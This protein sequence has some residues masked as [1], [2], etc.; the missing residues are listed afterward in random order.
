MFDNLKTQIRCY[1]KNCR[2]NTNH[3]ANCGFCMKKNIQLTNE[4]CMDF[5]K[6]KTNG[7]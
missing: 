2:F 6:G 3:K 5:M 7:S 4:G 1:K